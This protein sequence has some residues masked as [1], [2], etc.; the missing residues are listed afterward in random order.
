VQGVSTEQTLRTGACRLAGIIV[1]NA[2]AA[3]QTVTIKDGSTTLIVLQIPAN[4]SRQFDLGFPIATSLKV[5][6]SHANIDALF[7][8]A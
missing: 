5:T 6:P 8:V 1:S 4:D 7:V 3:V 2:N